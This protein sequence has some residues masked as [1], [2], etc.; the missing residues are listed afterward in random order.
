MDTEGGSKPPA[1]VRTPRRTGGTF[2]DLSEIKAT[3]EGGSDIEVDDLSLSLDHAKQNT[4]DS[5]T[6]L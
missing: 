3:I 6:R 1:E 2:I 5:K 4:S